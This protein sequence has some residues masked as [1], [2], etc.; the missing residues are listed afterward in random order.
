VGRLPIGTAPALLV[1]LLLAS[2]LWLAFHPVHARTAAPGVTKQ[3]SV[4][5]FARTHYDAYREVI[6]Q[7][8]QMHS[9]VKVDRVACPWLI[10]KFV[11]SAAE[12]FFVSRDEVAP[13]GER[14]KAI[15]FDAPR[16]ELGHHGTECSF[17]AILKKVTQALP[18][19]GI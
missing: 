8:E 6:P 12:F 18:R 16:V 2:G 19:S 14:E 15:P 3:L 9:G 13:T 11:D 5:T 10:K 17:E 7:F 1:V 4:W